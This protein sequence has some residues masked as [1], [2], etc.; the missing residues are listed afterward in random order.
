MSSVAEE[1]DLSGKQC[2]ICYLSADGGD[3]EVVAEFMELGCDCKDDLAIVH[4][5]CA[6]TWFMIK[7]DFTCEICGSKAQNV[8]EIAPNAAPQQQTQD[9]NRVGVELQV[10]EEVGPIFEPESE[11]PFR[12][13]H[14][15]LLVLLCLTVISFIIS[16]LVHFNKLH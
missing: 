1:V 13:E 16:M 7:G 11:R 3:D 2:R 14:K 8:E 5:E 4:K 10:V 6:L 12:M 15:F 9:V